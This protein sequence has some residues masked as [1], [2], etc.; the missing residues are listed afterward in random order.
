MVIEK[1]FVWVLVTTT[2]ALDSLLLVVRSA[3]SYIVSALMPDEG[4]KDRGFLRLL[5]VSK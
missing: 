4:W 5:T 2:E 3:V 1:Y